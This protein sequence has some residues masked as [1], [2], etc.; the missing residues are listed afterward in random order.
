MAIK[1]WL[2][3]PPKLRVCTCQSRKGILLCRLIAWTTEYITYGN[4]R[5]PDASEI[6]EKLRLTCRRSTN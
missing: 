4:S 2:D 5:W 6:V 3:D 1:F